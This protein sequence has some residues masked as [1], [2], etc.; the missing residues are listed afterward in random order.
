MILF[1]LLSYYSVYMSLNVYDNV[2]MLR[3]AHLMGVDMSLLF[4]PPF[5]SLSGR[6][7]PVQKKKTKKNS[8]FAP[9]YTCIISYTASPG[10][11][12]MCPHYKTSVRHCPIR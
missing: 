6:V 9:L 10:L 12:S 4:L 8:F 7:I 5:L 11:C 3:V 2:C 1:F